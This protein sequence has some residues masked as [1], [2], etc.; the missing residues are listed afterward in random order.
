[1]PRDLADGNPAWIIVRREPSI[2]PCAVAA[3]QVKKGR[4]KMV[5]ITKDSDF[6]NSPRRA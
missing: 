2:E 1:M 4:K 6:R 5:P 3:W